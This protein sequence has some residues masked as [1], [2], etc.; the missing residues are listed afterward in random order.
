M[1]DVVRVSSETLAGQPTSHDVSV[2]NVTNHE[3]VLISRCSRYN[4]RQRENQ[5]SR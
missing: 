2:S 5:A 3:Q 4:F 1:G